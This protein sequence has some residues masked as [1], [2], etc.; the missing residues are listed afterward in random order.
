[1]DK[2]KVFFFYIFLSN[3]WFLWRKEKPL[4]PMKFLFD[5]LMKRKTFVWLW[6]CGIAFLHIIFD[7]FFEINGKL[8]LLRLIAAEIVAVCLQIKFIYSLSQYCYFAAHRIA[9]H[10]A[11]YEWL[12]TH[13]DAAPYVLSASDILFSFE[14]HTLLRKK[15]SMK[16]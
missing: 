13:T 6:S 5:I 1:M 3:V 16:L 14:N 15:N 7:C 11:V 10:Y 4:E 9:T 12:F 8:W 2:N